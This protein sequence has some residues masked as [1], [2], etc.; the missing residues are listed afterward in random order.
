MPAT[1]LG[2]A[3]LGVAARQLAVEYRPLDSLVPYARNARTHSEA[4]G[5]SGMKQS[6]TMSLVESL[7]NVAI[8]YGIAVI[9]QILVFP[10]FG[11]STTLAE[12]MAMGAIFTLVS[13]ARSYCLRRLA[14]VC[15]E[16]LLSARTRVR[17]VTVACGSPSLSRQHCEEDGYSAELSGPRGDPCASRSRY[18]AGGAGCRSQGAIRLDPRRGRTCCRDAQGRWTC[19]GGRALRDIDQHGAHASHARFREDRH[20]PAG[21]ADQASAGLTAL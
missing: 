1:D 7:T 13:I 17:Q 8:G 16:P 3:D 14:A 6:R 5:C 10:L 20:L 19:R 11:L 12:N 9:T 4:Q 15:R 21:R 18:G 2:P